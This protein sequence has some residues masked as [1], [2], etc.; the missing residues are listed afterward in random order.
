MPVCFWEVDVKTVRIA[1]QHNFVVAVLGVASLV[2]LPTPAKALQPLRQFLDA[3]IRDGLDARKAAATVGLARA[4]ALQTEGGLFPELTATGNR[5]YEQVQLPAEWGGNQQADTYAGSLQVGLTLVNVSQWMDSAGAGHLAM[6]AEHAFSGT[7]AEVERKV[8]QAYYGLIGAEALKNAYG[9]A[10][11]TAAKDLD[12]ARAK[13]A[14]GAATDLDVA[15]AQVEAA[16]ASQGVVDADL[17]LSL[18]SRALAS[19]S[20]LEPEPG[21]PGLDVDQV[22]EADLAAWESLATQNSPALK[23]AHERR[24][25]AEDSALAAKAALIPAAGLSFSQ[26]GSNASNPL[27]GSYN[28]SLV[29]GTLT[30]QFGVPTLAGMSAANRQADIAMAEEQLARRDL[31]DAVHE[32]WLRVQSGLARCQAAGAK[33]EAAQ[34]AAQLA[35]ARFE[36]GSGSHQDDLQAQRDLITAESDL[37]KAQTGLLYARAF[38]R[39]TAGLD[40]LATVAA[41]EGH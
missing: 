20:G 40:P 2:C 16:S 30:W 18:D 28:S 5:E 19:L 41:R 21:T 24:L 37:I 22:Q 29:A 4:Q 17:D 8:A 1:G 10:E 27:E 23:E 26:T 31:D 14:A 32:A 3:A 35:Q 12:I 25:A 38:L 13:K 33:A 11:D 9:R 36:A 7:K 34:V 39:L 15:Q 6:A